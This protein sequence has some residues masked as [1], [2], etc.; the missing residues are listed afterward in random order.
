ME[1]CDL[2]ALRLAKM[3]RSREISTME[4][5]RSVF[6]R[7]DEREGTINA[8]I[9]VTREQAEKQ[10][11]RIDKLLGEGRPLP[12]IAGIPLAIKDNM[13]TRGVRTT[14]ASLMLEN[15]VPTYDST[16]VRKALEAGAVMVGKTNLDEFGMGSSTEN[17]AF[18]PTRN[19][20]NTEYV[21]GGSSGGSAAAGD[22]R[23]GT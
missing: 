11:D 7:I 21:T 4:I 16:A 20:I 6:K 2:N 15:F 10:A 17:S 9:T 18:G 14:C 19:P 23:A 8:F 22:G 13:C 1:L 12:M 3:L 5:L